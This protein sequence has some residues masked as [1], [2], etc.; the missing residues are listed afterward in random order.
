LAQWQNVHKGFRAVG[1]DEPLHVSSV[2]S[3]CFKNATL[4]GMHKNLQH[5]ICLPERNEHCAQWNM[6]LKAGG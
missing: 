6:R 2:A 4:G 5:V 3:Y 1:R